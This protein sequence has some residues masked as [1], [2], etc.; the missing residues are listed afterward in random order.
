MATLGTRTRRPTKYKPKGNCKK[1][2]KKH[3]KEDSDTS[4]K[5]DSYKVGL[6]DEVDDMFKPDPNDENTAIEDQSDL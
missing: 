2:P 5:K 6:E 4:E 3:Y 1:P